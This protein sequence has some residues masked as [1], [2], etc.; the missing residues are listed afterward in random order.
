M[1]GAGL[2][3][4]AAAPVR[5]IIGG[6]PQ[7]PHIFNASIRDNLKLARPA[8]TSDELAAAAAAARLL[9]WIQSLPR[10]WDTPVGAHGAAISGGERQRLALA[11]ALL[12]D[13]AVLILDEPTA[14][15]DPEARAAL[16]ADL[17]AL[18]TGRTTLLIT[19]ELAGLDQVDEIIVLDHGKVAQRGTHEQ[20]IQ[21]DGPYRQLHEAPSSWS[22]GSSGRGDARAAGGMVH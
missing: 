6:C 18:T 9:P 5:T 11:R 20:L 2:A 15:L 14:H 3:G 8:A 1:N 7:D 17:L 22:P 10:G 19:H 4:Y 12:A 16:T 13:P 21:A